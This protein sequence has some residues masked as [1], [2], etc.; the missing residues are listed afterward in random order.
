MS[1]ASSV[2]RAED[3]QYVVRFVNGVGVPLEYRCQTVSGART[4][5]E[6]LGLEAAEKPR[7]GRRRSYAVELSPAALEEL[8]PLSKR[9]RSRI[10]SALGR[11]AAQASRVTPPSRAML[12]AAGVNPPVLRGREGRHVVVYEADDARLS[13]LHVLDVD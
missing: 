2:S 11:L 9:E 6:E 10:E 7:R 13:V 3:G 8:A 12:V 1:V 4:L 5:M